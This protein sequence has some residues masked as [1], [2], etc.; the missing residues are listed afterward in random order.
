[1]QVTTFATLDEP[2]DNS[3]FILL[4]HVTPGKIDSSYL[5]SNDQT[6]QLSNLTMNLT[7]RSR[8]T[9]LGAIKLT[10]P[11]DIQMPTTLQCVALRGFSGPCS[12]SS[13][14]VIPIGARS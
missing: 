10:M 14:L 6:S 1:V 7:L 4:G 13:D 5:F 12:I 2:V 9:A 8:L 11:A 3:T